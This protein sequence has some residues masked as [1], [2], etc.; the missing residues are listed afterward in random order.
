MKLFIA[1]ACILGLTPFQSH[2]LF[3]PVTIEE[4]AKQSVVIVEASVLRKTT[5]RHS[6]HADPSLKGIIFTDYTLQISE[7]IKGAVRAS[8]QLVL[9]DLGGRIEDIEDQSS[10]SIDLKEGDTALFFL[11]MLQQEVKHFAVNGSLGVYL[12]KGEG[13]KARYKRLYKGAYWS[14]DQNR[15]EKIEQEQLHGLSWRDIEAKLR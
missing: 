13:T 4:L 11:N 2:A 14:K 7:P 15:L 10:A 12:K 1:L 8:S 9:Q 6:G 5:Y 3:L